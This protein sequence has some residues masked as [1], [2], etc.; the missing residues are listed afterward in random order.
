MTFEQELLL[1]SA[2]AVPVV[3]NTGTSKVLLITERPRDV[4]GVLVRNK[5][6][7]QAQR[8]QRSAL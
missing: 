7:P 4:I 8:G 5:D 6:W 1:E 3:A 2:A